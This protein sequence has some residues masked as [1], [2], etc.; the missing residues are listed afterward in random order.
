VLLLPHI[1]CNRHLTWISTSTQTLNCSKCSLEY[2]SKKER[3]SKHKFYKVQE[4]ASVQ[5]HWVLGDE[6]GCI[7]F[8]GQVC[9]PKAASHNTSGGET[10]WHLSKVGVILVLLGDVVVEMDFA[11]RVTLL[12]ARSVSWAAP[13]PTC[14]HW[15]LMKQAI[16]VFETV[17]LYN[18][19]RLKWRRLS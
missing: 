17:Q 19:R 7:I 13:L 18:M 5:T 4:I 9:H 8:L 12:I 10:Y 3:C 2:V 6:S 16:I 11:V 1:W 14:K 15:K